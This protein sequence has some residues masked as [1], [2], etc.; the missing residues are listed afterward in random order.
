M[1]NYTI[2]RNKSTTVDATFSQVYGY[3]AV[4][5]KIIYEHLFPTFLPSI[6]TDYETIQAL[7]SMDTECSFPNGK[8]ARPCSFQLPSSAVVKTV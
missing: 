3:T 5:L 7:C 1:G 4:Q 2:Q 6:E 8:V